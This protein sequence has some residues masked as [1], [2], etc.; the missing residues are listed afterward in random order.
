MA[1]LTIWPDFYGLFV[2]G[3]T[4]LHCIRKTKFIKSSFVLLLLFVVIPNFSFS[5][6][7][8]GKTAMVGHAKLLLRLNQL[9]SNRLDHMPLK[10]CMP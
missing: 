1:T 9:R 7:F 8:G 3:L 6:H 10:C 4:W 2:T 5:M